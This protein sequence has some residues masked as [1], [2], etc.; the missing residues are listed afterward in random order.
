MSI[1]ASINNALQN[2]TDKS[3]QQLEYVEKGSNNMTDTHSVLR[4]DMEIEDD[5]INTGLKKELLESLEKASSIIICGQP[6]SGTVSNTIID[7]LDCWKGAP[8]KITFLKDCSSVGTL[9]EDL[10][11]DKSEF[12][13]YLESS[14]VNIAESTTYELI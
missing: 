9:V 11:F 10:K 14:G 12:L 3:Q 1:V 6:L 13:K 4:S 2:W 5:I 7:I 8:S